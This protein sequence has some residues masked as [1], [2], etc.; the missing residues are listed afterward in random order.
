MA[1]TLVFGFLCCLLFLRH[2][3]VFTLGI[4]H[5]VVK[6]IVRVLFVSVIASK[7]GFYDYNLRVGPLSGRPDYLANL[8]Y[9]GEGA[10]EIPQS[11]ELL[12]PISV[13]NISPSSRWDSD[14]KREPV[15]LSYHLLDAERTIRVF[16][17]VLTPLGKAIGPGETGLVDLLIK[18]PSKPGDYLVQVD[19]VKRQAG[20]GAIIYFRSRGLK[21][22]FIPMTSR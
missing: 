15:Y 18:A 8:E 14:A 2:R 6:E 7:V 3:N 17:N 10:I 5:G 4:A 16:S 12:V 22:I 20:D 13:T 19:L 1:L 21:P 9:R 11:G